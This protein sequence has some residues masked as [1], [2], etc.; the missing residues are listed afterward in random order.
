MQVIDYV[1]VNME[2]ASDWLKCASGPVIMCEWS[3]HNM[4]VN[5]E[6]ASSGTVMC[7]WS[8]HNVRVNME[9]A[10]DVIS[11]RLRRWVPPLVT[12]FRVIPRV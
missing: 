11:P 2:C 10:S 1:R 4:R 3:G 5:M 6:C 7:E 9:C 8:G 12:C